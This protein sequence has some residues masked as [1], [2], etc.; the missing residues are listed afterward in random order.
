M[1]NSST[2]LFPNGLLCQMCHRIY[3][4]FFAIILTACTFSRPQE[5]AT[6]PI[7][8]PAPTSEARPTAPSL[9][10]QP[11]SASETALADSSFVGLGQT[12]IPSPP[13]M[14]SVPI[15]GGQP[16]SID[17]PYPSL[18]LDERPSIFAPMLSPK[19][20]ESLQLQLPTSL[21]LPT[22]SNSYRFFLPLV[23]SI[24]QRVLDARARFDCSQVEVLDARQCDALLIFYALTNG[25]AWKKS[26][27]W[28]ENKNPCTWQGLECPLP[29]Y[30][31]LKLLLLPGNNLDGRLPYEIHQL[32]LTF[33]RLPG[34]H[35]TGSIPP[36]IELMT[37][38][39]EIRLESNQLSGQVPVGVANLPRLRLLWLSGDEKSTLC[40]PQ[41]LG[42]FMEKRLG[43]GYTSPFGGYCP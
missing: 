3:V 23:I 40:I 22:I 42:S 33:L 16:P 29:E 2:A 43:N 14:V 17:Q 11:E 21:P 38:L 41:D 12:P 35:L 25:P 10:Q 8:Q 31:K 5:T 26:D 28:L 27:G 15:I 30:N 4:L 9:L 13:T 6:Y 39:E 24:D 36:S 19:A 1:C 7:A 34:N 37:D 18:R 20:I 32:P